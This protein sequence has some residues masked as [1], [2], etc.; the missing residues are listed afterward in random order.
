MPEVMVYTSGSQPPVRD[1]T[2][3]RID[4]LRVYCGIFKITSTTQQRI[5]HFYNKD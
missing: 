2:G 4:C 1:R 3:P 5:L